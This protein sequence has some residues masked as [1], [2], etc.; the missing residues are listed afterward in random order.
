[1]ELSIKD[2]LII[3]NSLPSQETYANML[4]IRD[5]VADIGFSNDDH[6]RLGIVEEDGNV[7]WDPDKTET[8]DVSIGITAFGIIKQAFKKIDADGGITNDFMDIYKRFV[9]D[10][11]VVDTEVVD[12]DDARTG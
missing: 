2:R 8:K 9:L 6:K 3:L 1:M 4:V 10:E 5:L 7:A 11:A 12:I